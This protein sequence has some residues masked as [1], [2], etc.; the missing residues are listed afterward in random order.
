M[1]TKLIDSIPFRRSALALA[2]AL[3]FGGAAAQ[4]SSARADEIRRDLYT[5]DSKA[6][7]GLIGVSDDN[8][9]FGQHRGLNQQGLY[10]LLDI[11]HVTRDEATGT[12]L[13]LNGRSLGLDTRELRFLHERQGDWSYGLQGSQFSR[14]EP[15][16]VNTGLQGLGMPDQVVSAT[17]PKR[18]LDLKV[19]HDIFTLGVRKFFLGKFDVQVTFRQ[20]ESHGDRMLGRGSTNVMEFLTEPI[21]RTTRQWSVVAGYADRKLQFSGGYSGSSYDNDMPVLKSTGGNTGSFTPLWAIALPPSNQA[22]QLHLSGGWN[23]SD[24]SR[25]AFKVSHQ[26]ATQ[27]EVFNPVFTRLAGAPES[28]N[29][30]LATSLAYAELTARPLKP[31]DLVATVR[32]E[33]RDD[34]TPEA[35]FLNDAPATVGSGFFTA[36]ATGLYK[37]RSFDQLEGNVEAAWQLGGGHRVVA[38]VKQ[39]QIHRNVSDKYRRVGMREK[40]DETTTRLDFKR[41]G[42]DVFN[43]SVS[44]QHAERGGSDYVIDTYDPN[45][46]TN[47]VNAISWADRSRDKL[48]L[49]ADWSPFEAWSLQFMADV[50]QDRYSGRE[51]GPRK[52]QAQFVSAD[53]VYRISDKWTAS[54]WISQERTRMQQAHRSDRVGNVA[55]GFDTLWSADLMVTTRGAGAGV[56]G[57]LRGNLDVGADF[58]ASTDLVKNVQVQTGGAGTLP[59][60]SLPEMFYK[61]RTL[62][63]FADLALERMSGVRFDI[64][65]DQRRTNDWTWTGWT[66]NGAPAVAAAARTSD[67]TTVRLVPRENV[68]VIGI[69]Y[70]LRW[71]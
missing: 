68:V 13:R 66:Y 10:G 8:R 63:L 61:V 55:L 39:E 62:K 5:L 43:G 7:I 16:I 40:N 26:I 32:W 9:R 24:T 17:A 28:L 30:K 14:R 36:G 27:N 71:R 11:D 53:T 57:K 20:D 37:P 19:D 21:D 48:R 15:L 67:G 41:S 2:L 45:A 58:S 54:G 47:K 33:D 44:L 22:H 69:A 4:D 29:G 6:A 59:V 50:S 49:T 12:W 56:K 31:L 35:R 52:G 60:A 25:A 1:D 23:L 65:Y 64:A 18:D 51:L 70:Q 3:A 42:S 38:G 46:L 34:R